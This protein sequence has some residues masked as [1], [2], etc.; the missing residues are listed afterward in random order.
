VRNRWS[1]APAGS[2]PG[3]PAEIPN[4]HSPEEWIELIADGISLKK[5]LTPEGNPEVLFKTSGENLAAREHC[6][7]HGL[8]K[9]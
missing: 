2:S 4:F 1:C 7:V 8:W 6:N 3:Y 9:S 5:F